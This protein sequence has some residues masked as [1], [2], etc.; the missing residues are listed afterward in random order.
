MDAKRIIPVLQIRAG[1]VV[2]WP[3]STPSGAGGPAGW[4]CRLEREG[5]DGILFQELP[6]G[7]GRAAWIREVAGALSIPFALEAPFRDLA[8]LAEAMEAGLDKAVLAAPA[9]A[10]DPLL[11]AAVRT[12][13]RPRLS[14]AVDAVLEA[15]S[16]R[17][18]LAGGE[19]RDALAWMA[20]LEQRGAGEILLR[21][22]PEAEAAAE[23]VQPGARLAVPVVFR[24]A[25]DRALA[26]EAL[27]H[28]AEGVAFPAGADT[29]DSWKAAL[30]VHGLAVRQ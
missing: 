2:E 20:E 10:E 14:V 13:G 11:A 17:V 8:D 27:L 9:A 15:G 6:G 16:W 4:A 26:A 5:A 19:G 24:S 7:G 1:Q 28:G 22:T 30:G 25:G 29:S 18:A 3:G 23:L 12:F 21:A